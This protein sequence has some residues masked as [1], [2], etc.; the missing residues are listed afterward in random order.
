MSFPASM[1]ELFLTSVYTAKK[2]KTLKET[3]FKNLYFE[4]VHE[5]EASNFCSTTHQSISVK[6][7]NV[8]TKTSYPSQNI[9]SYS[10]SEVM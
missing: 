10:S 3:C 8:S 7:R 5:G 1:F 6:K 2:K 9:C 4:K